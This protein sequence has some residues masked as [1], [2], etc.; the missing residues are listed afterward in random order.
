[1]SAFEIAWWVGYAGPLLAFGSLSASILDRHGWRAAIGALVSGAM[2]GSVVLGVAGGLHRQAFGTG[3]FSPFWTA[4]AF[5]VL[6]ALQ[7]LS[8]LALYAAHRRRSTKRGQ[9][10]SAITVA[11][12]VG[13][14]AVF[15]FGISIGCGLSGECL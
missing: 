4:A 15:P 7:L 8:A 5:V 11:V 3:G 10:L 14:L 13:V 1:M 2:L 9:F 12:I 6:S